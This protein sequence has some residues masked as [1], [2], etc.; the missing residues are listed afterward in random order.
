MTTQSMRGRRTPVWRRNRTLNVLGRWTIVTFIA[1]V[2][3]LLVRLG[4][5]RIEGRE[6]LERAVA[7]GRFLIAANHPSWLETLWLPVAVSW[8]QCLWEERAMP[9]S[10]AREDILPRGLRFMFH[11][12]YCLP[13]RESARKK[14]LT[15]DSVKRALAILKGY[16]VVVCYPEGDLTVCGAS[17]AVMGERR[18]A[19]FENAELLRLVRLAHARILPAYVS[20]LGS[21]KKL[22][23]LGYLWL[24]LRGNVMSISFG[25][26]YE[27]DPSEKTVDTQNR[28][29][30]ERILGAG[31]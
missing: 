1:L 12:L 2:F 16:G 3:R 10:I 24:L 26:P 23:P 9:W 31:A 29:L 11:L 19:E 30:A 8:P 28:E 15:A 7:E 21:E 14:A 20:F 18:I 27:L 25:E 13:V 5:V 4:Y 17:F 6:R 22:R